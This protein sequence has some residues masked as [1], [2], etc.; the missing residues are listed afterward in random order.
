MRKIFNK[1]TIKFIAVMSTLATIGVIG[2]MVIMMGV[3][4]CL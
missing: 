2:T 3:A 4:T 1:K